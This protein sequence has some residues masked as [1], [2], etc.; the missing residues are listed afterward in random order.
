M[1]VFSGSGTLSKALRKHNFE[2]E[3]IDLLRGIHLYMSDP[4]IVN[5][6]VDTSKSNMKYAHFA[7][8]CNSYSIARYPKLR[9]GLIPY[10][11]LS[12]LCIHVS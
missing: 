6:L 12:L 7:P 10:I 4:E 11:S 1:E 5:R 3:E 2:T 8:P 9:L